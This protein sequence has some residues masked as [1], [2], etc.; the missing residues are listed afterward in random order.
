MN[1]RFAQQ[2][3]PVEDEPEQPIWVISHWGL[4]RCELETL[5]TLLRGSWTRQRLRDCLPALQRYLVSRQREK[6]LP[7]KRRCNTG[8]FNSLVYRKRRLWLPKVRAYAGNPPSR[9]G[10]L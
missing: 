2:D 5:Q 10:I 3:E 6:R 7:K 1:R 8:S 4:A 9:V